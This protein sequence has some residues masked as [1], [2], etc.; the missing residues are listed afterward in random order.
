MEKRAKF[1]VAVNPMVDPNEVYVL[2][3]RKPRFLAKV[4][5]GSFEIVDDMDSMLEFFGGNPDK[6]QGLIKRMGDWYKA[7]CIYMNKSEREV[8]NR[9]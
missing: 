3:T 4:E 7:Y 2:H 8:S 9:D 5:R 1:M 6:V